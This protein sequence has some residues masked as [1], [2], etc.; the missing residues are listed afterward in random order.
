[1]ADNEIEIETYLN[2]LKVIGASR[3][4]NCIF[5]LYIGEVITAYF[6]SRPL[7]E[8]KIQL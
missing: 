4:A 5:S 3:N 8:I 7:G 6:T 1:M 2:Y